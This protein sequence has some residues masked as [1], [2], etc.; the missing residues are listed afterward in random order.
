MRS[1]SMAETVL[2]WAAMLGLGILG[3]M[4]AFIGILALVLMVQLAVDI[5]RY[6]L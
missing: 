4:I 3:V 6:G 5:W 1:A 2:F